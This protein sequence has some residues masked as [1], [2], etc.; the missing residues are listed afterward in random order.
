MNSPFFWLRLPDLIRVTDEVSLA[1]NLGMAHLPFLWTFSLLLKDQN[2]QSYLLEQCLIIEAVL[3]CAHDLCFEQIRKIS[4]FFHLKLI[5]F[6]TVKWC[7]RTSSTFHFVYSHFVFSLAFR[8]LPF[9]LLMLSSK[10][11]PQ[12]DSPKMPT[13]ILPREQWNPSR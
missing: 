1:N 3:R 7:R 4:H 2:V 5:I 9:R 11:D 6:T 8:L 10:Q 12:F 13:G